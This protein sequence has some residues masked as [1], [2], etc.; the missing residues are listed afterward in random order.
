VEEKV[1]VIIGAGPAGLTAAYELLEKSDIKPI[2]YEMSDDVGGISRT[3]NYKG[4]R[5][6]IGGHRF[7]SKSSLVM[8]WWQNIM[9]L[10]G[11][12]ARDDIILER[13]VPL[14]KEKQAPDPEKTDN[15]MLVRKRY[16]RILF[17]QKFFDYPISLSFNL[18]LN[19]GLIRAVIIALSYI[20]SRIIPIKNERTLED[21][22]INRFG[23]ELYLTFF[24]HYT[25]KVWGVPCSKIKPEW[26]VQRIKGLSIGKAI[27]HALKH[28][29]S[30][31]K[32]VAQKGTETSLIKQFLYPK[33]GAGQMWENVA[34]LIEARGGIIRL[35]HKVTGLNRNHNRI[36]EVEAKNILTGEKV[37][38]KADYFL[39][40]M[41]V[42]ELI[43]SF[44]QGVPDE[45]CRVAE[46]LVYRDM[47]SVGL[48]FKR[49]KIKNETS[50]KTVNEIVPD[51][52][53]YIQEK[54]VKVGRLQIF[55][56]WSPYMTK[57]ENTVWI[58]SEYFC[59]QPDE[60]WIKDDDEIIKFAV[61]ELAK[62]NIINKE[63]VLDGH[64]VR[65]PKAYP[66]YFGT[67][68]QF[69]TVRN[70][71]DKFENLFLIGRNGMHRYNNMDHS[72]LT[73]M[74]VV[75]NITKDIK[76][77]NNIWDINKES[78]YQESK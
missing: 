63:D 40:S 26:G 11:A 2:V 62:I 74:V 72:M 44:G 15:V 35:N 59:T 65:M 42:K 28:A 21:F 34:Q 49:L 73:A 52:W 61:E 66:A 6:D 30:K 33:L 51:Q 12:P 23:R 8:Q 29:I 56:N 19:L 60:L 67:Y 78:E 46:G 22:F 18:L 38:Q 20:K 76:T 14:S 68:E 57:D 77:K 24:K 17:S 4:Y 10:Q 69:D 5:M 7:F 47:I 48:L 9:P 37:S 55:N 45:V 1:A 50:I 53:I 25:E 13:S 75:E 36:A 43:Q 70:F 54:N 39:S 71:V 58:G 41:P 64:V 3:I 27:M 16:S 32:S 31:E